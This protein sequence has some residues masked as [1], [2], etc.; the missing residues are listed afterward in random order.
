MNWRAVCFSL[1]LALV[2]APSAWAQEAELL[3]V[4]IVIFDPGVPEDNAAPPVAGVFPEIRR[5]ESRYLPVNLRRLLEDGGQ[6]GVVRVLPHGGNLSEVLVEARIVESTGRRLHL[7]V[8]VTDATGRTWVRREYQGVAQAENYPLKPGTAP[9]EALYRRLAADMLDARQA[10]P[11]E[12]LREIRQVALMRYAAGL[13]PDAFADYLSGGSEQPYQLERLPAR[14]DPMIERVLRIR[15]QEYLFIDNVDEQYGRLHDDMSPTYALWLQYDQEQSLF[16]EDY[17]QRAASRD[18]QGKRG[19]FSAM[20]QSYYS[21]RSYRLQQQGLEEL[22]TGFNNET[23][24]TL[25]E[26]RGRVFRLTGTLDNQ[27]AEWQGILRDIFALETG[28][29]PAVAPG[30]DFA[31][32]P[33]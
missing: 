20:Q 16:T 6:W 8:T 22:A 10:L 18:K 27:Y 24:P 26:T 1:A 29:P 17:T 15:N 19:S 9:F 32:P 5:A 11:P 21:Y 23:A 12:R 30:S 28:L 31:T 33:Q 7:D 25:V 13:S 3:D 4:G 14:G 2:L